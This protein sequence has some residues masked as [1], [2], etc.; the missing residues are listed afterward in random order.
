[1]LLTYDNMS[2]R[3][4]ELSDSQGL[5]IDKLV[6]GIVAKL[7]R[8]LESKTR[9]SC[10]NVVL[11]N[12]ETMTQPS[13]WL[14]SKLFDD[15]PKAESKALKKKIEEIKDLVFQRAGGV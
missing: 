14:K 15:L 9:L 12:F 6:D 5:C 7:N 13:H 10:R 2:N 4:T 8:L 11:A 3:E 1:M